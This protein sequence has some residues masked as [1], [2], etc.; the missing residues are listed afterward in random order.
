MAKE[1]APFVRKIEIEAVTALAGIFVYAGDT[2]TTRDVKLY[3][4]Y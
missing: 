2:G 1:Y 3:G 4:E